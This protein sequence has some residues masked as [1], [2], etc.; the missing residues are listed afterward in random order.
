MSCPACVC[1]A[2]ESELC[3][4]LLAL[5]THHHNKLHLVKMIPCGR[6]ERVT[7]LRMTLAYLTICQL[8]SND[9]DLLDC[10]PINWSMNSLAHKYFYLEINDSG[11]MYLLYTLITLFDLAIGS[12]VDA[13]EKVIFKP[14][15]Q[16][17]LAH[18]LLKFFS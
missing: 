8:T 5:V 14:F 12:Q 3:R 7:D 16:L 9:D 17:K 1:D 18:L 6:S 2:Q 4:S 11:D 15:S 10:V 13:A